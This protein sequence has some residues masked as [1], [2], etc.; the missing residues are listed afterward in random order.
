MFIC[1]NWNLEFEFVPEMGLE[2]LASALMWH[3]ECMG[4]ADLQLVSWRSS[5]RDIYSVNA[6]GASI[7]ALKI[8]NYVSQLYPLV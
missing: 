5:R 1:A 6:A 7:P 4:R 8:S 2:M 3:F